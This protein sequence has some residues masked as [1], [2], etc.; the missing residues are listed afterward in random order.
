MD[1]FTVRFPYFL[2]YFIA[3]SIS[4]IIFFYVWRNNKGAGVRAFAWSILFEISWLLGYIFEIMAPTLEAKFFWDKFQWIGAFFA[5][6]ALLIFA[7]QF[8]R[9]KVTPR[10]L[11]PV[12]SIIPLFALFAIFSDFYPT[13]YTYANI[14]IE[15]GLPFDEFLYDFGKIANITTYYLYAI[16]L[17]YIIVL[18]SGFFKKSINKTQLSIVFAGILIPT[19]GAIAAIPFG[20]KFANQ[21]DISPLMFAISNSIMAFGIF[22]YRLFNALPFAREI[23]FNNINNIIIVLDP[24]N[25]IID[26]NPAALRY[27]QR[28]EEEIKDLHFKEITP[29]LY[30]Q[31]I[32]NND[33]QLEYTDRD[34][35]IFDYIFSPLH[36]NQGKLLGYLVNANEITEQK[37]A[38]KHLASINKQSEERASQLQTIAEISKTVTL[39][40]NLDELLPVI[41]QQISQAFNFYHVGI[42]LIQPNKNAL[43]LE[44]SNSVNGMQMLK[45]GYELPIS[46]KSIVG[47]VAINGG[48]RIVHDTRYDNTYLA[49]PD[50]PDTRSEIAVPL[51]I[52]EDI[53][54]VLDVQSNDADTFTAEDT[55]ILETLA[56]QVA[57][58][59]E[60]TRQFEKAQIALQDAEELARQYV[61]QKWSQLASDQAQIGVGYAN[62]ELY[63]LTDRK[64]HSSE[65]HT[66]IQ[67]PVKLRGEIIGVLKIRPQN[68]AGKDL[69]DDTELLEAVAERAALAM[70]N[71][72][73]LEDSRQHANRESV[74]SDISTKIGS[75]TQMDT[76]LQTTVKELGQ[77]LGSPKVSFELLS[78][79]EK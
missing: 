27:W 78:P 34:G 54:G 79:E 2:I 53:L 65:N 32:K 8:T 69:S 43:I 19:I 26:A 39:I 48:I 66:M 75:S 37:K 76:I 57:V 74:L 55:K 11:V 18:F 6:I 64:I 47:H 7:L 49:H 40:H 30:E 14:R 70:E 63:T 22:R 28:K 29:E 33:T 38:E 44:A 36:N 71:A 15:A 12:L 52:R 62:G 50:L 9:R 46:K 20:I 73:L 1:I 35:R 56:S 41:A 3:L 60:N 45:S 21:R 61:R 17:A 24:R 59:I 23:L 4:A 68:T 51:H 72:R 16:S 77:A 58:A 10:K 67:V 13:E 31:F 25:F 5:P 42:F